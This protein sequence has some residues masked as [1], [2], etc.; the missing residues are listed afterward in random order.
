MKHRNYTVPERDKMTELVAAVLVEGEGLIYETLV[1]R[2]SW[3]RR[4]KTMI[5]E[6]AYFGIPGFN[7]YIVDREGL[8]LI[9][10][11]I[12]FPKRHSEM[13]ILHNVGSYL[14]WLVDDIEPNK[15]P[16]II[17]QVMWQLEQLLPEEHPLK[18]S[19]ASVEAKVRYPHSVGAEM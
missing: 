15:A 10:T 5:V 9:A 1:I 14:G 12:E 11:N 4:P 3:G 6:G 16:V 19:S 2:L 7:G 13:Q 17:D 8:P 18:R